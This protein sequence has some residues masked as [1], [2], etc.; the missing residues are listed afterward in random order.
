[1]RTA[2]A[3]HQHDSWHQHLPC[4]VQ[5]KLGGGEGIEGMYGSIKRVG[6]RKVM[7]SLMHH[8]DLDTHAHFL[9]VGAG[10]GRYASLCFY[11]L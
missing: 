4:C 5:S 6:M 8:C 10:L 7:Q 2:V 1:M 11:C 3:V 9:D